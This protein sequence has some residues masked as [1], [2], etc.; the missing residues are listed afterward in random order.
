M[1]LKNK[2]LGWNPKAKTI[3]TDD[4]ENGSYRNFKEQKTAVVTKEK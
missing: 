3:I 4:I 2:L 1:R